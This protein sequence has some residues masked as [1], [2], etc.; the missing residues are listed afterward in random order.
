MRR[1][2]RSVLQI[3]VKI[4][5]QAAHDRVIHRDLKPGNVMIRDD[6]EVKV[7]DFGLARSLIMIPSGS[8]LLP[9]GYL[10]TIPSEVGKDRRPDSHCIMT[11][12]VGGHS[13]DSSSDPTIDVTWSSDQGSAG[14]WSASELLRA[15]M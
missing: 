14:A 10:R 3:G 7:L 13:G 6:D 2:S 15:S 5:R 8:R 12:A 1:P 9:P 11:V 4:A